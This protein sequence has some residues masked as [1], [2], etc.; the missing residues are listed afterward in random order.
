MPA[1]LEGRVGLFF[2]AEGNLLLHTC[3]LEEAAAY[4]DFLNY[5]L[6]HD[7]VWLKHYQKK[8]EVDFDCYPRG[9]IIYHAVKKEYLLYYDRCMAEK[10]NEMAECF[11]ESTVL[12]VQDEHYQCH[13]C[14]P[15]YAWIVGENS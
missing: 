12:L 8:Y 15:D 10:A 2:L 11:G 13:G 1:S 3:A 9:R 5:P 4:G 14:N 7:A 6:S